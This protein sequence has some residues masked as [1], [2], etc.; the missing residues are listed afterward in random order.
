MKL[1]F[2]LIIV[3]GASKLWSHGGEDHSRPLKIES[4]S[5][6]KN[7]EINKSYIT[8]VKPAFQRACFDCHG[9]TTYYPWYYKI[10]GIKQLIDNDIKTAKKHLDFSGD[11]PFKSHDSPKNDLLAISKALKNQTMPPFNYS[12]MHG[13][14]DFSDKEKI[15]IQSWIKKSIAILK[16]K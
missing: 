8:L 12:L 3:L 16:R 11:F 14:V 9:N 6:L 10:P 15:I 4:S 2:I 1:L 5:Q 13:E 7:L